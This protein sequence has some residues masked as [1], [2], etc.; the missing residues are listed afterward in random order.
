MVVQR[1]CAAGETPEELLDSIITMSAITTHV[2]DL[3]RG[4]PAQGVPVLLD[5]LTRPGHWKK[6][7]EGSTNSDGRI[8]D[9]LPKSVKLK[10]GI[11]RLTFSTGAYFRS[12][13]V[14]GFYPMV[15]IT[16]TLRKPKE[17]HHIPLL[18][19]PFGYSTYR[20]S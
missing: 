20:G 18:L 4:A 6:L 8:P 13:G 2:L 1:V 12:C 14:Q 7:A 17:H 3:S 9:F 16:F 5:F 11:Y 15:A 10:T 19:S